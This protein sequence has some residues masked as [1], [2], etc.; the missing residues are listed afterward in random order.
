MNVPN[1]VE[2]IAL[3][4][5]STWAVLLF[6]TGCHTTPPQ[7]KQESGQNSPQATPT[8][9]AFVTN[10]VSVTKA[11]PPTPTNPPTGRPRVHSIGDS[12][13]CVVFNAGNELIIPIRGQDLMDDASDVSIDVQTSVPLIPGVDYY[14]DTTNSEVT[15][16]LI[17]L[18]FTSHA[19]SNF[20]SKDR[21]SV[22]INISEKPINDG[23][24]QSVY[25]MAEF[26]R[27]V[28][29]RKFTLEE[30]TNLMAG[31]VDAKTARM[32]GYKA[33]LANWSD[34]QIAALTNWFNMNN[35]ASQSGVGHGPNAVAAGPQPS[36]SVT[37]NLMDAITEARV[38]K[39]T[40]VI[41]VQ[42]APRAALLASISRTF[43]LYNSQDYRTKVL[44]G[45]IELQNISAYPLNFNESKKLFGD[46]VAI[47]FF[48]VRLTLHNPTDQ[49]QF[50]S[51]G[52]VTAY[53][54]A[55][56]KT[57]TTNSGPVFT[58]PINMTPQSEQQIYTMVQSAKGQIWPWN[59]EHDGD[60]VRDWFFGGL[61]FAG[62][63][64]AAYG[65]SF[66]ASEDYVKA[67]AL[68]TGAAFPALG[69]LWE[70]QRPFH[71]LNINNFSMP[72]V[73]KIPKGGGSMDGK[74]IFFSKGPLQGLLQDPNMQDV[75]T[76]SDWDKFKKKPGELAKRFSAPPVSLAF[77]SLQIPYENSY[78][79]S[80]N[81]TS[82]IPPTAPTILVDLTN[83]TADI[84]K[85]VAFAVKV[86][87]TAP[88]SYQWHFQQTNLI[89]GVNDSSLTL[90][91]L[92]ETNFGTYSVTIT[93][94][95]GQ[96]NTFATL[97]KIIPPFITLPLQ[98]DK[99]D[100]VKESQTTNYTFK[101]MAGGDTPLSYHWFVCSGSTTNLIPD[102]TGTNYTL[103]PVT[104][105]DTGTYFVVVSNKSI[106]A[107]K[108]Q[109]NL[110]VNP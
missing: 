25:E 83:Q 67:V 84:S 75:F 42:R 28:L 85:S 50:V 101:V 94:N 40:G 97:T 56:V 36:S 52:T 26:Q 29:A 46:L 105:G 109:T 54:R 62:A 98:G 53:G 12:S 6:L 108:S 34:A 17:F 43:I 71:L 27:L 23:S 30:M 2:R 8:N 59:S 7:R 33:V 5:F 110:T 13:P 96:I 11:P 104:N 51:L 73:V 38:F 61:D 68:A 79:Q 77:D 41:E 45:Q 72:D 35:P 102:A 4:T 106:F 78:I 31:N 88:F 103:K 1:N 24:L 49:D 80:Q 74:Y 87:G 90:T 20:S 60:S 47:N 76:D 22:N 95:Y 100:S 14:L 18:R 86:A 48:A 39:N 58:V 10:Y 65:T 64:A 57:D 69:K 63:L 93:N 81:I 91:N 37:Q 82:N 32:L 21:L 9:N 89:N 3:I 107:T 55:L 44:A 66:G 99:G 92:N 70:D 16:S 19:T 15:P